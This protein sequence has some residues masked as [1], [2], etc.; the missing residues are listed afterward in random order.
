MASLL[1]DSSMQRAFSAQ[2]MNQLADIYN[3]V[4]VPRAIAMSKATI[5]TGYLCDLEAPEFAQYKQGDSIPEGVLREAAR[6]AER[7]WA[8]TNTDPEEDRRM[9]VELLDAPRVML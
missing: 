6:A 7:N 8:W 2:S 9:A 3:T 5:E 4:R 1:T